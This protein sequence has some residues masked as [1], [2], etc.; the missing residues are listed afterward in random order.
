[1]NIA[2]KRPKEIYLQ[3]TTRTDPSRIS[4]LR[5]YGYLGYGGSLSKERREWLAHQPFSMDHICPESDIFNVYFLVP[6]GRVQ[7]SILDLQGYGDVNQITKE[8]WVGFLN[9]IPIP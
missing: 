6:E 8:D 9:Q 4:N 2:Q 7:E 3:L 1:M 5:H